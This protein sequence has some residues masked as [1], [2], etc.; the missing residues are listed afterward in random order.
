MMVERMVGK[1]VYM[2]VEKMVAL[3]APQMVGWRVDKKVA[4]WVA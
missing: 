2:M 3:S 4:L 1:M